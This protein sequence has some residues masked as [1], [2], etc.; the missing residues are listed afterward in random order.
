MTVGRLRARVGELERRYLSGTFAELCRIVA[1]MRPI[2]EH[3]D[4]Q[5]YASVMMG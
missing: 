2:I 1:E 3:F 4:L 5:G